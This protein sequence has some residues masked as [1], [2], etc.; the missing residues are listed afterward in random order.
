L[1]ARL[2]YI[3]LAFLLFFSSTGLL[4]NKHYC[5]DQLKSVAFFA[6]AKTCQHTKEIP[7]LVHGT[8]TVPDEDS[9]DCC[10]NESEYLKADVDWVAPVMADLHIFAPILSVNLLL[11]VTPQLLMTSLPDSDLPCRPPPLRERLAKLQSYL[12]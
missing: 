2:S 7:C 6:K 1:I 8:M 3:T 4:M 12:C 9:K 11:A 5:Q 10:N